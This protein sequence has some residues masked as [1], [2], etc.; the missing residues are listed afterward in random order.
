MA[1]PQ[2][3]VVNVVEILLE[4]KSKPAPLE[5]ARVRHPASGDAVG[6]GS[7]Q[8]GWLCHKSGGLR[9]ADEA[10]GLFDGGEEFVGADGFGKVGV[11]ACG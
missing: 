2:K 8:P 4:V 11:H 10:G 6:E 7:A 5:G 3:R 1:V 9:Y